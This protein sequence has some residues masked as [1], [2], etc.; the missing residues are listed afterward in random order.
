VYPV[1]EQTTAEVR[2]NASSTIFPESIWMH[3]NIHIIITKA[4]HKD[5][6]TKRIQTG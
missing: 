1:R 6:N 2:I 4:A 3:H 5:T